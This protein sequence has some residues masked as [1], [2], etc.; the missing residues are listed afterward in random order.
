MESSLCWGIERLTRM[1]DFTITTWLPTWPMRLHPAFSK[2][3]TASFPEMLASRANRLHGDENLAIPSPGGSGGLL[4]LGPQ[5][6]GNR[7][8]DV[9]ERLLLVSALRH[10][11]RK[12]RAFGDDPAVFGICKRDMENHDRMLPTNTPCYQASPHNITSVWRLPPDQ[13]IPPRTRNPLP[14]SK[15]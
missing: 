5:P 15:H 4:V 8:L 12:G 6:R 13:T 2:A 10:A 14:R 3:L 11:P 9:G 1:P 7:F